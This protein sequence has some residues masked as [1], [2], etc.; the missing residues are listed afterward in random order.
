MKKLNNLLDELSNMSMELTHSKT[1]WKKYGKDIDGDNIKSITKGISRLKYKINNL[2][3]D[4]SS[5]VFHDFSE[6][7]F[8]KTIYPKR[9]IVLHHTV[10][11][12]GLNGDIT[13]WL[14]DKKRIGTCILINRLGDIHQ[15]FSSI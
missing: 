6:K 4:I 12:R 5:I 8:I 10:S 2:K 1:Q 9:Q 11:G 13:W 15:V 7:E 14:K 3:L